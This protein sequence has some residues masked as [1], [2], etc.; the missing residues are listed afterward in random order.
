VSPGRD[1]SPLKKDY[2]STRLPADF[3]EQ[4]D[5]QFEIFMEL[6]ELSKISAKDLTS[7]RLAQ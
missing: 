4:S 2:D 5:E 1:D 3:E 7:L 6:Y